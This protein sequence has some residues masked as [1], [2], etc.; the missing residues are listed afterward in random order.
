[1]GHLA[2]VFG[3]KF[4]NKHKG[5]V[6]FDIV[7]VMVEKHVLLANLFYKLAYKAYFWLIFGL[8]LAYLCLVWP[9]HFEKKYEKSYFDLLL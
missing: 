5:F 6:S 1:M 9:C 8:F 2:R 4:F 7:V 3:S